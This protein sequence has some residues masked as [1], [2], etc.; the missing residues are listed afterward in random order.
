MGSEVGGILYSR[1]FLSHLLTVC[2]I[3]YTPEMN[4]GLNDLDAFQAF[5]EIS[6]GEKV[7]GIGIQ[8][9]LENNLNYVFIKM[10]PEKWEHW[11]SV[12]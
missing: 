10:E 3:F 5:R 11:G 1:S 12:G 6:S 4:F 2:L 7:E 9:D 8:M